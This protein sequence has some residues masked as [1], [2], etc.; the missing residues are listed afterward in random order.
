MWIL[1]TLKTWQI[2]VLVALIA[3]IAG[4]GYGIYKSVAGPSTTTTTSNTLYAQVSYDNISNSVTGSGN[5]EFAEEKELTLGSS[6]EV[7]TVYVEEGDTVTKGQAL[8]TDTESALRSVSR[9]QATL[10][11][12]QIA[13][14]NCSDSS[15]IQQKGEAVLDA[16]YSLEDALEQLQSATLTAPFAGNVISVDMLAGEEGGSIVLVDPS[17]MELS[18][19]VSEY[20]IS[21]VEVGQQATI[22]VDA[23]SDIELTGVVTSVSLLSQS[24]SGVV[25]Y[26][27]TIE[28]TMPSDI[29][30]RSGMSA[31]A[32]IITEQ[33]T[34][35]LVVPN[36]AIT[37]A[38]TDNPT[39]TVA[40]DDGTTATRAVT[41]GL[42]GD[43]YTEITGGLSYGDIVSY[44]ASSTS[45]S[46]SSS[47][48]GGFP[49]GGMPG[50]MPGGG[51]FP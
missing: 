24:S 36:K 37:G 17:A 15:C 25:S 7:E 5:L 41:L 22:S 38:S 21:Q 31:T 23:F 30:L 47:S 51:I 40:A 19:I 18:A 49:G 42:V 50:D 10:S 28:L 33:A 12:A 39:V 43:S 8:A 13:L 11:S 44:T 6:K 2:V 35:V 26:P 14:H 1:R 16:Q 27:V 48:S 4:G 29:Q 45:T 9:A 46:S 34:D 3:G 32:T 20:D